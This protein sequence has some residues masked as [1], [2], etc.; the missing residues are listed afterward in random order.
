MFQVSPL[1]ASASVSRKMAVLFLN[2]VSPLADFRRRFAVWRAVESSYSLWDSSVW[3]FPSRVKVN[4]PLNQIHSV[5]FFTEV[6]CCAFSNQMRK[7]S[8]WCYWSRILTTWSWWRRGGIVFREESRSELS[9]T[10]SL[11]CTDPPP[12]PSTSSCRRN[13]TTCRPKSSRRS[14]SRG[15]ISRKCSHV[16]DYINITFEPK[17]FEELF[18][19]IS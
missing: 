7:R 10:D 6:R 14:S 8:S 11:R 18:L 9:W 3:W 13:S 5:V 4:Q 19:W 17:R 12:T 15:A 2:I 16:P 1:A